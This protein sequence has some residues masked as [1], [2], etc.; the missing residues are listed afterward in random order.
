ML[1]R[2][3]WIAAAWLVSIAA[4][5]VP[6]SPPSPGPA[7]NPQQG[8]AVRGAK[9][10]FERVLPAGEPK[11]VQSQRTRLLSLAV[12]RG[13]VPSPFLQPGFFRA[14]FRATVTVASRDRYRFRI[15]GR[16]S[17]TLTVNGEQLLSGSIGLRKS[18]ETDK[19]VRL[20]KGE[21]E[22]ALE[23]ESTAFG[24]GLLR[25]FWAPPDCGFEPIPPE[26][27]S[28]KADDPEVSAGELRRRGMHLYGERRCARCHEFEV[29][30]FGESAYG[31]LAGPGPDLRA[32]GS[33]M[34][35]DWLSAWLL[36]PEAFRHDA[37]M[38]SF[39]LSEKEADDVATWLAELGAPLAVEFP[40]GAAARGED[41]FLEL[42]CIACHVPPDRARDEAKLGDRLALHHVPQKWHASA[43]VGYLQDPRQFHP[44]VR[45]P[46]FKLTRA[47]ATELAAYLMASP[48]AGK[49]LR[50]V[51]GDAERGRKLAQKKLC[52]ACHEL[53]VPIDET[54]A[55]FLRNLKPERGCLS[56]RAGRRGKAPDHRLSKEDRAALRAFLPF[57][58][59]APFRLAP[60]DYAQRHVQAQRCTACHG[61]DG[62]P[63]TWALVAN[64]LALD[65][66]L[67]EEQDPVAQGVPSL[68]WVGAKLQPSWIEQFV[69][70]KL[71][72]PRPWLHARM[73]AFERRGG[74]ISAGL[75]REHGYGKDDEPPVPANAQMA[76]HGEKLLKMGTGFGCVQCHALGDEPPQQVFERQGIEL[77][78][79]HERLRHE[80]YSRWL[81]DPPRIDPESRM[82]KYANSKGKTA[83]TEILGGDAVQQF[84]AMWQ[85]L[86]SRR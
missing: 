22:L 10:T 86:G 30:R 28:W 33:R 56:E 40:Q 60:M 23:F 21:N 39:G 27:L 42:G 80:Y 78:L 38:P 41:R 3:G 7:S 26:L 31:E 55:P 65:E 13:E 9:V 69:T 14:T 2:P 57:A 52:A 71:P 68:T 53:D 82:P 37:T 49:P 19:S 11:Q 66:P 24:D 32:A 44:A 25:L 36:D 72:S 64:E 75:V 67:P 51:D 83:F 77:Y 59:E 8:A 85:F 43:L 34:K 81:L 79:A 76:I 15:D 4:L 17:A 54:V 12:E 1:N 45:M 61:L 35:R 46:D 18:L 70:G 29:K 63:S 50:V 20:S 58:N 84:E 73:P 16:G 47:E 5:S 74:P 62:E 48:A 6:G